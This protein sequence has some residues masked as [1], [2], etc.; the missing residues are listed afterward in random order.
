MSIRGTV[1]DLAFVSKIL[2]YPVMYVVLF[3]VFFCVVIAFASIIVVMFALAIILKLIFFIVGLFLARKKAKLGAAV[4]IQKD[5]PKFSEVARTLCPTCGTSLT[6]PVSFTAK[7]HL[8]WCPQCM[9]LQDTR[10]LMPALAP[11]PL[12]PMPL[13]PAELAPQAETIGLLQMSQFV[14]Q[15]DLG[16]GFEMDT[17]LEPMATQMMTPLAAPDVV[18]LDLPQISATDVAAELVLK[19]V[20][21][22]GPNILAA[23]SSKTGYVAVSLAFVGSLLLVSGLVFS[24]SA[25]SAAS[26]LFVLSSLVLS[27]L[28]I[29]FGGVGIKRSNVQGLKSLAKRGLL[30]GIVAFFL[31]GTAF[32]VSAAIAS[33]LGVFKTA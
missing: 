27:I 26:S 33:M 5:E 16:Y 6:K 29:I 11:L 23:R 30:L 22:P 25:L 19:I 10:Q 3:G 12:P 32:V 7:A 14:V 9:K 31:P 18:T 21:P 2:K 24:L 20:S 15:R 4:V 13:L 8:D 1:R 17:I 28:S